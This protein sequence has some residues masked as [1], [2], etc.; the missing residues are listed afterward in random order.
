MLT[1]TTDL[2]IACD[3]SAIPA[4]LRAEHTLSARALFQGRARKVISTETDE[5]GWRLAFEA[6]AFEKL[7][8]WIA[9]ERLCCPFLRFEVEVTPGAGALSLTLSGPAGTVAFLEQEIG[10]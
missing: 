6:D 3:M 10:S 2:P 8:R 4:E 5:E 9:L 1:T 7:T